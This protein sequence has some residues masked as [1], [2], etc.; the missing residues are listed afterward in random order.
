MKIYQPIAGLCLAALLSACG[1]GGD[2]AAST[3]CVYEVGGKTLQG[4]VSAVHDGDSI[5]L[6]SAGIVYKIR[7]D[8]IDAPELAQP[9]GSVSQSTLANAVLG[10]TVRVAY[11][12][13]DKYGR[14]VGAVFT[15]S[16]AYV[17]LNQVATGMAWFYKAY[18]CEVK[19]AIR[20]QFVQAENAAIAAQMG[21]WSQANPIS[22]WVYRNGIDPIVPTCSDI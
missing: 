14:V 3:L 22:P 9:F 6:N 10:K 1:G 5:T 11:S 7:L 4:T 18:Q 16:C 17:N 12:K 19:P 21:L 13:T 2:G 8:A 20:S 15:D